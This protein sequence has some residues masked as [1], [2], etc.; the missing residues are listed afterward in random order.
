MILVDAAVE[1]LSRSA[2]RA[3]TAPIWQRALESA[4]WVMHRLP[5]GSEYAVMLGDESIDPDAASRWWR[6]GSEADAQRAFDALRAHGAP[7]RD[8]DLAREIDAAMTLQPLPERVVLIVGTLPGYPQDNGKRQLAA[9]KSSV[10]HLKP[11][12]AIDVLLMPVLSYDGVAPAYWEL[13]LKTGGSLL[14]VGSDWPT[15]TKDGLG[16]TEYAVFVVDVS[17]SMHQFGWSRARKRIEEVLQ[18]LR[19][20]RFFQV[21]SDLG[22]P[23]FG[24]DSLWVEATTERTNAAFGLLANWHVASKS[25]PTDGLVVAIEQARSVAHASVYLLG[26]DLAELGEERALQY[27]T[28]KLGPEGFGGIHVNTFA[29]PSIF[30]ATGGDT[31]TQADFAAFTFRL[32]VQTGGVVV[33]SPNRKAKNRRVV[34]AAPCDQVAS[35]TPRATASR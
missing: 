9:L 25:T 11:R 15:V 26:D 13:A 2:P 24:K 12:V 16:D 31:Y 6:V 33:G 21:V 30:E 35:G 8:V 28:E 18:S 5:E 3:N 22:E 20:L 19:N 10:R 27:L 29:L 34:T 14:T 7:A 4:E 17:G 23:L 32:A 1:K